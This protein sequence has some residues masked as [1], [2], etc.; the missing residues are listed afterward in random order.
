MQSDIV[1]AKELQRNELLRGA[2]KWSGLAR[3]YEDTSG[4]TLCDTVRITSL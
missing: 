1:R 4:E 2:P 3:R